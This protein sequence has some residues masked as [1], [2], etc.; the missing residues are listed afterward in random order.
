MA[1]AT[2]SLPSQE[3]SVSADDFKSAMRQVASPVA[4]ITTAHGKQ[5][6]GLTATAVCS[7]T[8]DP[9]TILVCV[10]QSARTEAVIAA[11]GRLVVN[12][13][14]EDQHEIARIFS[15]SKL[16]AEKRFAAGEWVEVAT[17]APVLKGSVAS[18]DCS[19]DSVVFCGTH[20]IYLSRVEAVASSEGA[21]LLYRDGYFRRLG[22]H[23]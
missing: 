18:F 11:S 22:T 21:P 19:V 20:S 14:S 2:K 10:N 6:A 7:A 16:D 5:R 23:F 9:P 4:I 1:R 12:F 17:G 13:L 8:A 3:S 15:S